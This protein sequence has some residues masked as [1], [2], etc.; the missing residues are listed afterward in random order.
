MLWITSRYYEIFMAQPSY[1]TCGPMT[2]HCSNVS[3][4]V[5]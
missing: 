3:Q 2:F 5:P 4:E 1:G